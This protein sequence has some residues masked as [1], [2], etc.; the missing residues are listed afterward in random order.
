MRRHD[1]D[2]YLP[3]EEV[4]K[5]RACRNRS[6]SGARTSTGERFL[7]T[8]QRSG[9]TDQSTQ[10]RRTGMDTDIQQSS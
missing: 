3:I 6:P 5:Y 4:Y 7:N 9:D 10:R 2:Q 1:L 8:T